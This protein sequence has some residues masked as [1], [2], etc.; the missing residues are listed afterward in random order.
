VQKPPAKGPT[1]IT[2]RIDPQD[3]QVVPLAVE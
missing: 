1:P 2:F 3:G